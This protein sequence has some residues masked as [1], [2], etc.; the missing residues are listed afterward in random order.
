MRGSVMQT[1]MM[2]ATSAVPVIIF[3]VASIVFMGTETIPA[4]ITDHYSAYVA[5]MF[6]SFLVLGASIAKFRVCLDILRRQLNDYAFSAAMKTRVTPALFFAFGLIV[7]I[8]LRMGAGE[9]DPMVM[10]DLELIRQATAATTVAFLGVVAAVSV[11]T[12]L[13]K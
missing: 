7:G 9:T 3:S 12:Q 5:F 1:Y 4:T 2:M 6:C 11:K 8:M 13:A 10:G